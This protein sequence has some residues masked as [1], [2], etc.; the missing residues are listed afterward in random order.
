LTGWVL[1]QSGKSR[2]WPNDWANRRQTA[3]ICCLLS[4]VC[5]APSFCAALCCGGAVLRRRRACESRSAMAVQARRGAPATSCTA[6]PTACRPRPAPPRARAT[7]RVTSLGGHPCTKIAHPYIAYGVNDRFFQ[8]TPPHAL[9]HPPHIHPPSRASAPP[10][11]LLHAPP[12]FCAS[13]HSSAPPAPL[14]APPRRPIHV[15]P[16]C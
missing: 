11:K 9:L 5:C 13:S 3:C 8:H 12:R 2:C 1:A 7:T 4:A 15:P 6:R 14:L 10:H 16:T